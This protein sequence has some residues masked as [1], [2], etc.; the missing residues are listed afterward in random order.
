MR[1][2]KN[3]CSFLD[4]SKSEYGYILCRLITLVNRALN[5]GF[6]QEIVVI[7]TL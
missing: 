6:F 4:D 5:A 3:P 7:P 1:G 2:T